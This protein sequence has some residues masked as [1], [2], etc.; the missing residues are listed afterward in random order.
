[1]SSTRMPGLQYVDHAAY[2]V[3]DLDQAVSF[4]VDVLGCGRAVPLDPRSGC[5]VHAAQLRRPADAAL[6]LSMLRMPPNLNVE[7]FQWQTATG[8]PSIPGTATEAAITSASPWR[9]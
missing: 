2:T 6:E 3:P 1:M 8:E 9:T 7:L 5:G 4:F